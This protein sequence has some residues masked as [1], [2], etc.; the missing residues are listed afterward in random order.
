MIQSLHRCRLFPAL[1]LSLV[2]LTGTDPAST[3]ISAHT[4]KPSRSDF[5]VSKNGSD[6]NNGSLTRPW[7]T[8]SHAAASVK[9]GMTVHVSSGEYDESINMTVSGNSNGRIRFVSDRQWEAKVV[10]GSGEAVW[11]SRGSYV[12]IVGF[13][14]TG[15]ARNGIENLGSYGRILNNRVH[16]II[17]P[18]TSN[19]GSGIN[20]ASEGAGSNNVLS[21]NFIYNIGG[22]SGC[23]LEPGSAP[24]G[25]YLSSP[26][27]TVNNNLIVNV[28]MGMQEWH[29]TTSETVVNN[30]FVCNTSVSKTYGIIVGAGDYPCNSGT[31]C[32]NDNSYTANNITYGCTYGIEE[33]ASAGGSIGSGNQYLNNDNYKSRYPLT[34]IGGSYSSGNLT[35]DPQFVS[36]TG[37]ATGDY[38]LGAKSPAIDAGVAQHA[39]V[40]DFYGGTRPK[41]K[42]YDIGAYEWGAARGNWPWQ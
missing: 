29:D 22:I 2:F 28:A 10:G 42:G 33:E 8:I 18:C 27:T 9:A 40:L 25:I 26:N 35:S 31:S 39:P 23:Q 30:T 17:V 6:T 12:D 21:G 37:D 5:Y 19:G 4:P 16:D 14:V 36:N 3:P 13:D 24:P 1:V 34:I 38:R 32:K 7:K 11:L 20:D 41:G 15:R